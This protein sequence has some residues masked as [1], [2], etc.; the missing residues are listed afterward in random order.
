MPQ[1]QNY[2]AMM[3]AQ[4]QTFGGARKTLALH[5]CCAPC[6][7]AVLEQLAQFFD[8]TILYYNPNTWPSAEW[9][10]RGDELERFVA[11]AG[12]PHLSLVLM[13]HQPQDFYAA[14]EGLQAEPERG[15]RCTVCYRLRLAAAANYAAEQ[16]SDYFCSTLSIS[17]HKDAV[18]INQ[19]GEALGEQY[20]IAHLPNDFKKKEG[21][22]RSL[23]LSAEYRLYRQNYCGCEFSAQGNAGPAA[24]P[25]LG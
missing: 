5:A 7:T 11:A 10:R 8:I 25:P 2:A 22:K 16:G 1:K 6:S 3:Q 13:P 23:V 18:R 17:P 19:I 15:N 4:L 14:I 24:T 20:G 12:I 9:Q 21:Y